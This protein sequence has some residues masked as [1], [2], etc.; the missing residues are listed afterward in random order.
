VRQ[1]GDTTEVTQAEP[2]I[3]VNGVMMTRREW[4]HYMEDCPHESFSHPGVTLMDG[5]RMSICDRC[6]FIQHEE[7]AKIIEGEAAH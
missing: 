7:I 4:K 1:S 5:S 6:K 3:E 2:K